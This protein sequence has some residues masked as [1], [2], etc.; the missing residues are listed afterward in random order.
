MIKYKAG[1]VSQGHSSRL[2]SLRSSGPLPNEGSISHL[3][4]ESQVSMGA[5]P[6]YL[7]LMP[8]PSLPAA[9]GPPGPIPRNR[10]APFMPQ[11]V[12]SQI[13]PPK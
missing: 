2:A 5:E 6:A 1:P 8:A 10:E 7:V 13:R 12:D 9:D 4:C 11:C 3:C